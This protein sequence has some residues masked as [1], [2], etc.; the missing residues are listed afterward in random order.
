M[1]KFILLSIAICSINLNVNS[2]NKSAVKENC[3]I[4]T[5][6]NAKLKPMQNSQKNVL[7]TDQIGR[8]H[9]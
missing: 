9:V 7:G 8:A 2:Q 6:K 1:N 3:L 5:N 4:T